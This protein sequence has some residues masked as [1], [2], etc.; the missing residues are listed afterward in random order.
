M[1]SVTQKVNN[2]ILGISEQP[3]E[4]K[5][6]GQVNNLKNGVP[7]ITA[8]L[9]KR[10]GSEL[11]NTITPLTIDKSKWFHIYTDLNE[12]YIGQIK[13]DGVT[14]IWRCSDG[15]E[16]PVDYAQ[17]LG[18]GK[19]TYL[20]NSAISTSTSADIQ[21]L[22]INESTFICNRQTNVTMMTDAIS[23]SPPVVHEAF[24]KLDKI[25][26]GKQYSLDIYDPADST[27]YSFHRATSLAALDSVDTSGILDYTNSDITK[28]YG[29]GHCVAVSRETVAPDKTGTAVWQTTPPNSAATGKSNLKYE[30]D[31]RC[32]AVNIENDGGGDD[33]LDSY[34]PFADLQFGGEG[35]R[36]N[37]GSVTFV[38]VRN[39]GNNNYNPGATTYTNNTDCFSGG[40]GSGAAA[41]VVFSGTGGSDSLVSVTLTAGGSGYTSAPTFNANNISGVS[42]GTGTEVYVSLGDIHEHTSKK[43]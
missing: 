23:K 25:S 22:T 21:P 5:Q 6:P 11:V 33:Y 17:V 26:Y 30:L 29:D 3:D 32:Q 1:A 36:A 27:T 19:C 9:I 14:K 8:G 34:H 10:P 24:I 18:S 13:N 16:I 7:D 41:T 31:T 20:D 28:G 39:V 15:I 37:T 35:W 4:L 2:Y 38:Q 42:G 40:G 12:Q 43:D